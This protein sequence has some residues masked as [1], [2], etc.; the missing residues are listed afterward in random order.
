MSTVEMKLNE[1]LTSIQTCKRSY[2]PDFTE[3]NPTITTDVPGNDI[4]NVYFLFLI[5]KY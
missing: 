4:Y 1:C 3:K 2:H 5:I